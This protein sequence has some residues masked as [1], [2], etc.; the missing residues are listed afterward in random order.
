[1]GKAGQRATCE[2]PKGVNL[3]PVLLLD[4]IRHSELAN[5]KYARLCFVVAV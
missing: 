1:M 2:F 5:E 3:R 4:I